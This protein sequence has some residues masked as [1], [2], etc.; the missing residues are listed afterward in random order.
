MLLASLLA[1]KLIYRSYHAYACTVSVQRMYH[2]KTIY[3]PSTNSPLT[4]EN[5]TATIGGAQPAVLHVVPYVLKIMAEEKK[6]VEVL[7]TCEE[8]ISAGSQCPDELG[9]RLV[10]EGIKLA[11]YF[12]S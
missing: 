1:Y 4:C 8:V 10:N 3:F 11:T 2:R 6:G 7:K 9:D 5:L 12:A